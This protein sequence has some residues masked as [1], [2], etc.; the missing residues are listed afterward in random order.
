M[1]GGLWD[2]GVNHHRAEII[3]IDLVEG[4]SVVE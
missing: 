2:Y 1:A 4:F 3:V